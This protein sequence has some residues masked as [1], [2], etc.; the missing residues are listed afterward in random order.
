[1]MLPAQHTPT[2]APAGY[3]VRDHSTNFNIN[4]K[5]KKIVMDIINKKNYSKI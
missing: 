2:P 1:M 5:I 3:P 4:K